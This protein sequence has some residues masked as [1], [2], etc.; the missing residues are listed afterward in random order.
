M[1]FESLLSY[2]L[3]NEGFGIYIHCTCPQ[4]DPCRM[5]IYLGHFS[6]HPFMTTHNIRCELWCRRIKPG[7]WQS[8][9]SDTIHNGIL[10]L[11]TQLF[12][13][14]R[15]VTRFIFIYLII[16]LFNL[17]LK[18]NLCDHKSWLFRKSFQ[19]LSTFYGLWDSTRFF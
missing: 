12:L 13:Q 15:D 9:M 6:S 16:K 10:Q 7:S 2:Q 19:I 18:E 17:D 11:C 3:I 4:R 1:F 14:K 8:Q 5:Q